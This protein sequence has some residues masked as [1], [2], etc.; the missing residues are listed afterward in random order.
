METMIDESNEH[1]ILDGINYIR[2]CLRGDYGPKD[3]QDMEGVIGTN[4]SEETLRQHI[5]NLIR[6]NKDTLNEAGMAIDQSQRPN[7][8]G[9][10]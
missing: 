7:P 1:L 8:D 10:S 3:K 5:V 2:E 4:P 9:D 6:K